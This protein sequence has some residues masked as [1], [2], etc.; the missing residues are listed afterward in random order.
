[1][2][3]QGLDFQSAALIAGA[4]LMVVDLVLFG[5]GHRQ[6]KRAHLIVNQL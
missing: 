5:I 4:V 6:F 2:S 3:F 1:M